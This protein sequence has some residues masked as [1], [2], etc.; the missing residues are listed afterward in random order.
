VSFADFHGNKAVVTQLRQMLG[1]GRLPH[2]ILLSGPEG[3]GKYR[4]ALMMARAINCA[5][6]P[7]TDGLP[8]FCGVC[9]PCVRIGAAE[10]LSARIAE[11]VAAR[12][13]MRDADKRETRILVQTD[14]DVL[15]IPPDPPQLLVKVGQVRTVIERSHRHPAERRRIFIFPQAKFMKEAANSLLKVLEEP[16]DAMHIF[17]LAEHPG[18]LL[19][20][21]RSRCVNFRLG[22]L[23]ESE[24]EV[25]L[26]KERPDWP[27][28]QRQLVAK[29][30]Q[31]APERALHFD[32]ESYQASRADAIV[33]LRT[34]LEAN[35]HTPLFKMTE[36]Y[37]AGAEG[38][39]K[40]SSLLQVSGLLL[41]D[42]LF[43][44]HGV[45]DMVR[46]VD[47]RPEIE[48]LAAAASFTWVEQAADGLNAVESGMRRNL[49]RS[50][51]LDAAAA[52]MEGA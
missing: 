50:L 27:A 18:E 33:L 47:I 11:A 7:V 26:Q 45:P 44:Q 38:A 29:L 34:A 2:S 15:V 49:L 19:P 31:G 14:P 40:L 42:V 46:N 52:R 20:T 13:E 12:D 35:D 4:L 48:R 28:K 51:S 8:D 3:V 43:A 36:T 16:A 1:R 21:M 39:G 32:L 22:A 37:R 5:V 41:E 9:D 25:L 23:D 17:L 6:Q 24:I 30:A 10:D